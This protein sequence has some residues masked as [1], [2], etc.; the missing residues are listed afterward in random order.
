MLILGLQPTRIL[1]D[2]NGLHATLTSRK[3]GSH[4]REDCCPAYR[5]QHTQHRRQLCRHEPHTHHT[6]LT[7]SSPPLLFPFSS[8]TFSPPVPVLS[9]VSRTIGIGVVQ[10]D[11]C[12]TLPPLLNRCLLVH[13]I[14]C[15]LQPGILISNTLKKN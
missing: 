1:S 3:C 7:S 14:L 4:R 11:Y 10:Y 6:R 13:D 12:Y 2:T 9:L 8:H 15:T 5:N